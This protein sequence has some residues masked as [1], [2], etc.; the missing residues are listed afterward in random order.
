MLCQPYAVGRDKDRSRRLALLARPATY[1][2]A[3]IARVRVH[4]GLTVSG[5]IQKKR[6][7]ANV[8]ANCSRDFWCVTHDERCT[9]VAESLG[10]IDEL[11]PSRACERVFDT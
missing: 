6:L 7:K 4:A 2:F 8:K 11:G 1:M 9:S 10:A 5:P 3:Q